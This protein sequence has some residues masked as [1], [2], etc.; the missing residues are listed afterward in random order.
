MNIKKFLRTYE[1]YLQSEGTHHIS[2]SIMVQ[3]FP[4]VTRVCLLAHSMN[5]LHL[6]SIPPLIDVP[7]YSLSTL[8]VDNGDDG[9]SVTSTMNV[10]TYATPISIQPFRMWSI[11]LYKGTIT[12]ENWTRERR[13]VLQLLGPCHAKLI[14]TLGGS[15]GRDVDK[16]AICAQ[17]GFDWESLDVLDG[18]ESDE[19]VQWPLVLPSCLYYLQLEMVG[20]LIDCGSHEVALCRVVKMIADDGV[21]VAA[22]ELDC[23]NTRKLREMGIISEFGRVVST[24]D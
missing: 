14:R 2:Q 13:G 23:L 10:L 15:S 6:T 20:D 5:A 4:F 18:E 11:S 3:F 19:R 8:G 24:D 22:D 17:L 1:D 21:Q 16:R 7:T 9:S 12:H